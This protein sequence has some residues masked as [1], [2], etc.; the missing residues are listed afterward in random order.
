VSAIQKPDSASVGLAQAPRGLV[1]NQEEHSAQRIEIANIEAFVFR[2]PVATPV[3]TSFGIMFDRPMVLVRVEDKDG[4]VGWGEIW[5]NYPS[6]GAEHRARLVATAIKSLL[7]GRIF[8]SPRAAFDELT[9]RTRILAIQSGELGPFAQCIAGID[10]AIWDLVARRAGVALWRFLGGAS[11]AV[12]VY[13]SGLN[14]DRPEILAAQKCD[15][16]YRAFKL[17][18]GF[19][20]ERDV[21][22]LRVLRNTL[23]VDCTLMV[24]ANQAW[25][26][27][28]A[29]TMAKAIAPFE[30]LWLEEPL[31]ADR[32]WTEW[33][34]L[35]ANSLVPLAAGENLA[36]E[37][38]FEK[39]IAARAVSVLQPDA[40]KW[41]GIS[42]CL[43][44]AKRALAAGLKYC[45]HYLGGGIG[46]LASAHLLA[47]VGGG[48]LLEIDANENV[49]RTALMGPLGAPQDGV[50]TVSEAAGLG[51]T[52]DI[53]GLKEFLIL[54]I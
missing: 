28:E 25:D 35:R 48:G 30:L 11:P 42:G 49:L 45:P 36:G 17:K 18:V 12:K 5:C 7:V 39:A 10:I 1:E 13:A 2:A 6:C 52:P 46:L 41:G 15:Q 29:V 33:R 27:D 43:P 31:A 50:C 14:P 19:G 53:C 3:R 26:L 44:V 21:A 38:A 20:K 23:S 4:A 37:A 16:G 54:Q 24:D 40:A 32:P 34:H 9:Y 22:N 8:P 47:A 51:V